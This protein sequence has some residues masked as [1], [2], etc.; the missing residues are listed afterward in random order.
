[1]KMARMQSG[2]K[3]QVSL[4]FSLGLLALVCLAGMALAQEPGDAALTSPEGGSPTET[5]AY[6]GYLEDGGQAANGVYDFRF[7]VW[8]QQVNGSQWGSTMEFDSYIQVVDGVFTAYLYPAAANQV[9]TGG[10]RWLQ[11]EVRPGNS[12]GTY[13]N[14]GRQPIVPAPYAWSL[15]PFGLISGDTGTSGGF[16]RAVLNIDNTR[17]STGGGSSSAIYAR[18]TTGSAVHGESGG[19]GVYGYSSWTHAVAGYSGQGTA[20]HFSSNEGYGVYAETQGDDHWDHGGYFSANMGYGVYAT[21]AQNY[22]VRGEGYFGVRG[23][24]QQVGV[25]GSSSSGTGTGVRGSNDAGVGVEGSSNTG[26][27]VL[28]VRNGYYKSDI[29][30]YYNPGGLFGG[31]NG[32]IGVTKASGGY[33]VFG[34]DKSTTAGGWAGMFMS[35][36]GNGVYISAPTA[37]LNVASGTKNAVVA[38]E[39]G[40]RLLYSEEA[41]EVWF[42]DY[43]FGQLQAG[44][45]VVPI[46]AIYAQTV[47]LAEPYHVFVQVYGDAEVYVANRTATQF[48]VHLREGEPDIEFSYR[49]VAK[50][51]GYE[52]DRLERAPWADND[53]N[54]Y[55]EKSQGEGLRQ[56]TSP[57]SGGQP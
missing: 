3:W 37:G 5:F 35:Q 32:V 41:T 15:R 56:G 51:L 24:G 47:N 29:A 4:T 38:T 8:D 33:G 12:I 11:I 28:G 49:I 34:W 46:D 10:A 50:R 6:Q 17:P 13:T 31:G 18:A 2:K 16:G 43:G 26:I 48:E 39:E 25:I 23:D 20:G 54:L 9:F 52:D 42:A 55:P 19:V 53:P 30:G 22:G 57:N 27:G 14:L 40:S 44:L 36:N 7:S 21:S 1:M 45:A